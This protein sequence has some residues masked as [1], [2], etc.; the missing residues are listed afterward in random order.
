MFFNNKG[1]GVLFYPIVSIDILIGGLFFF[2]VTNT[3]SIGYISSSIG[4]LIIPN[5]F[6]SLING[7]NS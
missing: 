5:V 1:M 7:N 4:I 2:I 3:I 6:H